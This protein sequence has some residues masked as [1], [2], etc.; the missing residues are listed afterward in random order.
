MNVKWGSFGHGLRLKAFP[1]F[2]FRKYG[3]S[4]WENMS[5]E[6]QQKL[7]QQLRKEEK[8]IR[9]G[10]EVADRYGLVNK[11]FLFCF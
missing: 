7:L 1:G 8:Q 10:E 2:C 4:E 9:N 5:K 3:E 6:E 11:Q